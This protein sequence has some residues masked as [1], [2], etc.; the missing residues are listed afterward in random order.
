MQFWRFLKDCKIHLN[1]KG[2]TLMDFDR[3]ISQHTASS[4]ELHCPYD[5]IL[6]REFFDFIVI[7]AFKLFAEDF[8]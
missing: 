6:I 4:A 7:I 3:L 8:A 5:K 2:I 1:E